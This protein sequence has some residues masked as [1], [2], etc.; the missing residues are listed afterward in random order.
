MS[1][2]I[3]NGPT[4]NSYSIIKGMFFNRVNNCKIFSHTSEINGISSGN[5]IFTNCDINND[6]SKC[7]LSVDSLNIYKD[8]KISVNGIVDT[9]NIKLYDCEI[10]INGNSSER[11][12]TLDTEVIGCNF[13]VN[14]CLGLFS[15]YKDSYMNILLRDNIFEIS[16]GFFLFLNTFS[17]EAETIN[18]IIIMNNYLKNCNIYVPAKDVK[19][20]GYIINNLTDK[21]IPTIDSV[22]VE[23]NILN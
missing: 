21:S 2:C 1:N 7:Y 13:Y 11:C 22:I 3:I 8:C 4:L 15:A 6:A 10:N 16:S 14:G 20:N 19:A 12:F 5:I 23:N 18:N 9:R 17:P